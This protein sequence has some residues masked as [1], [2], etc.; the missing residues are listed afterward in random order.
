MYGIGLDIG[1]TNIKVAV[2]DNDFKLKEKFT[3]P[4]PTKNYTFFI[5]KI[6]EI[7]KE[8]RNKYKN[9]KGVHIAVAG[10]VDYKNGIL[11]YAPNL[12]GWKN[13]EIKKDL[14]FETEISVTIDNDANMAGYGAYV[15]ELKKKYKNIIT[16]TLGTGV[17]GGIVIDGE[18]VRGFSSTAGEIGHMV[19]IENGEKCNCGNRGC[20]EAYCGSYGI[21]REFIKMVGD[22]KNYISR[23]KDINID[24]ID[25]YLIYLLAKK[26]D[27]I[28][29]NLWKDYGY[30][31]GT[32][33][34]NILMILNPEVIVLSGGV[35]KAKEFFMPY[36]K[37][38][39]NEY[40]IKT[41]I[42]KSKIYIAKE[43]DLGVIGSAC[44]ALEKW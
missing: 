27:K 37:K 6:A 12:S 40:G 24:K 14:E 13:K 16:F 30:R 3:I 20:L 23:Y 9:I 38:R 33:I 18:I 1:G 22:Y 31:L 21:V 7:I 5:K 8:L 2:I 17:G 29:I 10:D 43:K 26:G 15:F 42:K 41:P 34:G 28:S 4:T 32:G 19:I 44:Y 36:L 11:R 35:S 39:L 25:P